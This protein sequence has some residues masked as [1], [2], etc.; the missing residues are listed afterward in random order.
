MQR[1]I[2]LSLKGLGNTKTNPLVGCV[3][4]HENNIIGEGYH[5]KY[6]EAHAEVAAIYSVV[7]KGLLKQATLYVTLEPCCHFGKTPPCTELILKHS[8]PKVVI[9][10][11]DP[12]PEVSGKGVEILKKQGVIVEVGMLQKEAAFAN[13]RFLCNQQ[14]KRPYVILKWAETADGFL[15][16]TQSSQKQISGEMA[17]LLLH[18]WRSEED[19]FLIGKNTLLMDKP[20]LTN[21]KWS[22][23][24][25]IRIVLGNTDQDYLNQP[26]FSSDVQT[27]LIGDNHKVNEIEGAEILTLDKRNLKE[28]L[29]I[30]FSKG[31][32]SLVV[33]GGRE[34]LK[35]FIEAKLFDEIRVFKSKKVFFENGLSAPTIELEFQE[36]I[37]LNEDWLLVHH[38]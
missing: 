35:S 25:P 6:G 13:R 9:A 11:L 33:E 37:D 27:I 22:G 36:N 23:K 10:C 38:T 3:I 26:I 1:A 16:G 19:A 32:S 29:S 8:I 17:S 15:A 28:V 14:Q 31:I 2:D 20:L 34:V 7:D 18:K 4:V 21:R 24:S 30:L 12:F 5:A